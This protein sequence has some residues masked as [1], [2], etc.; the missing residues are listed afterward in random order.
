MASRTGVWEVGKAMTLPGTASAAPATRAIAFVT[1]CTTFDMTAAGSGA[2]G[3]GGGSLESDASVLVTGAVVFDSGAAALEF[4]LFDA[5]GS[6]VAGARSG[7]GS[8]TTALSDL[9]SGS[10]V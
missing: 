5:T 6:V 4:E 8:S 10:G 1:G 9:A 3:G 7:C 2:G